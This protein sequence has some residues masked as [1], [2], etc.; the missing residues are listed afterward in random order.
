MNYEQLK[1]LD[2]IEA[3]K[4]VFPSDSALIDFH[5]KKYPQNP[6][7][8]IFG[9]RAWESENNVVDFIEKYVEPNSEEDIQIFFSDICRSIVRDKV[10]S[11]NDLLKQVDVDY[12]LIYIQ[13]ISL[14]KHPDRCNDWAQSKGTYIWFSL[15]L[16]KRRQAQ[17]VKIKKE[18]ELDKLRKISAKIQKTYKFSDRDIMYLQ[19][20]CS[21]TK[22][23]DLDPSLNTFLYLW[24]KEQFTG[25]TTVA[26]YICSFLNGETNGDATQHKSKLKKE[27]QMK[28]FDIPKA[29]SSRCTLIDEGGF[30]D[31]QKVYD[32]FKQL[33]TSNSCEVEFK[34]KTGDRTRRCFRNYIMTSNVDPIYFVQDETERRILAIHFTVPEDLGFPEIQA[35][36]H[37]FVLECNLS[38]LKLSEIY[39][40]VIRPNSQV[41]E[42][43][44]IMLELRDIFSRQ[45]ID[46]CTSTSSFNITN[47]MAF[48]EISKNDKKMSRE[49]VKRVLIKLYGQPDKGQRFYKL[50]RIAYDDSDLPEVKEELPF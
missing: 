1:Q 18:L 42:I 9:D 27:M 17:F 11:N 3:I 31:M 15:I 24:S 22:L 33:I 4:M 35:M 48:N 36:W 10:L 44:N 12:K 46:A 7:V 2:R 20:F 41:G 50:N 38:A 5:L 25:K 23:D 13:H 14:F 16:P 47:V 26:S 29:T 43:N 30:F 28:N 37:E 39:R 6:E 49:V 21:Q 32:D 40:E 45:R 8:I 19:Y 34:Y